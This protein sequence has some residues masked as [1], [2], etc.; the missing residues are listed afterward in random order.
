MMAHTKNPGAQLGTQNKDFGAGS[1][2]D[3][4]RGLASSSSN[5]NL[6]LRD[7]KHSLWSKLIAD[8]D[9]AELHYFQSDNLKWPSLIL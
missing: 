2:K 9:F 5:L 4:T 3:L 8:T 1:Q 7:L 6:N